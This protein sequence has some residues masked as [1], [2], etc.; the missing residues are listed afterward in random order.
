MGFTVEYEPL[1]KCLSQQ[2]LWSKY[3]QNVSRQYTDT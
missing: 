3:V 2:G 1:I